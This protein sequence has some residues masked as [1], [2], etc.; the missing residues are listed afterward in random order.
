MKW[1]Y[2][3]ILVTSSN[4]VFTSYCQAQTLMRVL[5]ITGGHDFEREAFFDIFDNIPDVVYQELVHPEANQ[6][7]DSNLI[8][9]FDVLIF[10]DMVQ[11]IDD[12][13]KAAFIKVL[14]EGKGLVFLHHSLVSYQEWDEFEKII[15]GRYV[16]TNINQ[17]S[18][19]YRHDVDVP[20]KIVDK[21]HPITKGMDDF[22]IH[23]EVYGNYKVLPS[24]Q[25]L[26]QTTHPE[27]G[28]I[29]GWTNSYAK[30]RIVYLQLGH[31]HYAYENPSYR[32]LIKQAAVWVHEDSIQR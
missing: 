27:S 26:L 14:K 2:I 24:V 9:N 5:I 17:D 28:K 32:R 6:I 22:V 31:D 8:D 11:E 20:V 3:I 18:S 10:Y 23:D 25:P 16:L 19:T 29:V 12:T 30:S 13:Q 21:N 4:I 15:G 1:L 7:F